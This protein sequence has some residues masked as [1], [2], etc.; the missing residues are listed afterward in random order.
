MPVRSI[1]AS[2]R[3]SG[4]STSASSRLPAARVAV[5]RSSSASIA[6]TR[7]SVARA[8]SIR[9]SSAACSA[10]AQP[11]QRGLGVVGAPRP[12][13]PAAGS[14]GPGR[15]GRRCG[16]RAGPGRPR[17]RCRCRARRSCQ[18]WAVNAS[19]AGFASWITLG[20]L[21]VGQPLG[22]RAPRRRRR[23]RS[24]RARRPVR[25]RWRRRAR[26][27]TPVPR[28]NVPPTATPTGTPTG[29]CRSSQAR[30]V[31][32]ASTSPARSKPDSASGSTALEVLVEPVAQHPELQ[33]VEDPVHRLAV[34]ARARRCPAGAAAARGRRRAG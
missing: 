29:A 21:G 1:S 25:R 20:R 16:C 9:F 19:I 24:G 7:S 15:S 31:P 22:H 11:V 14:A 32:G 5:A 28:P 2:T 17:A 34:P 3:D 27:A 30:T 13:A 33:R 4:C 26:S 12:A 18:P 6:S 10:A 8:R 23:A